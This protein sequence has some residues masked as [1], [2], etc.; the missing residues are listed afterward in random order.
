MAPPPSV[1]CLHF[2]FWILR[3]V[4]TPTSI[5]LRFVFPS[6]YLHRLDHDSMIG[7][8]FVYPRVHTDPGHMSPTHTAVLRVLLFL[9]WSWSPFCLQFWFCLLLLHLPWYL[10]SLR[11]GFVHFPSALVLITSVFLSV[12]VSCCRLSLGRSFQRP[13]PQYEVWGNL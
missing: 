8:A 10:F 4:P 5:G 1:S 7:P 3:L 9:L 13:Q 2:G 6:D 12:S 11:C